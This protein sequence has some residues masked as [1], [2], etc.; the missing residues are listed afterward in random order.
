MRQKFVF[1]FLL[2]LLMFININILK[3]NTNNS[4]IETQYLEENITKIDK[5]IKIKEISENLNSKYSNLSFRNELIVEL[6]EIKEYSKLT[7]I[8]LNKYEDLSKKINTFLNF[9]YKNISNIDQYKSK[10]KIKYKSLLILNK[11]LEKIIK[12]NIEIYKDNYTKDTLILDIKNNKK[13]KQLLEK[14]E[15]ILLNYDKNAN[16][17]FNILLNWLQNIYNSILDFKNQNNL[18][19]QEIFTSHSEDVD[20]NIYDLINNISN[21]I[22]MKI[23]YEN[24]QIS[25]KYINKYAQYN[26]NLAFSLT[27]SIFSKKKS[28]YSLKIAPVFDINYNF[29]YL[30]KDYKDIKYYF[31]F[32]INLNN[33]YW[34]DYIILNLQYAKLFNFKS[35]NKIFKDLNIYDN[36]NF[37]IIVNIP[38]FSKNAT[39]SY[40]TGINFKFINNNCKFNNAIY[41]NK[42]AF[43]IHYKMFNFH[44]IYQFGVKYNKIINNSININENK[45]VNI[46]DVD[47]LEIFVKN[48]SEYHEIFFNALTNIK[49]KDKN[50]KIILGINILF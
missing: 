48:K 16:D 24:N 19:E 17:E 12:G 38:F 5:N 20:V 3:A 23:N 27:P 26:H 37:N 49:A 18:L 2:N 21:H 34:N 29:N 50:Y 11:D 42:F 15:D 9:N 39:I 36:N 13:T 41:I 8:L 33:Y 31:G 45:F 6:E 35:F 44:N 30:Q 25:T 43:S 28:F 22:F 4:N 7:I 14:I 10:I 40:K 1:V 47:N 32:N 46:L